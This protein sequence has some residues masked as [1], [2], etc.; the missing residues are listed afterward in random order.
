MSPSVA[1]DVRSLLK[2]IEGLQRAS[3]VVSPHVKTLST[4]FDTLDNLLDGGIPAARLTE[5]IMYRGEGASFLL[6]LAI[7]ATEANQTIA[8]IDAGKALDIRGAADAGLDLARVL[9][10]RPANS[11]EALRATD[12]ILASDGFGVVLADL[13]GFRASKDP[14]SLESQRPLKDPRSLESQQPPRRSSP[15]LAM[16]SS[17]WNRLAKR[18]EISGSALVICSNRI[19]AGGAAALGLEVRVVDPNWAGGGKSPSTLEGGS[20]EITILHQ[21][22][23]G[24]GQRVVVPCEI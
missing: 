2:T 8:W 21:K 17:L 20:L 19:R 6:S 16:A 23:G 11:N 5:V 18:A 14:R 9:W 3:T 4:G 12:L 22:H 7:A 10:V 24:T 1:E 13:A 15:R